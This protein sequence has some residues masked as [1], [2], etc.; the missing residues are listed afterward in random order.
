MKYKCYECSDERPCTF[1]FK[2]GEGIP[3]LCPFG[4]NTPDWKI[5]E[6]PVIETKITYRN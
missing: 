5:I 6:K 4:N 1:M 2:E 3:C